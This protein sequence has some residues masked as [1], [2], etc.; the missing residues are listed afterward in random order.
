MMNPE[1]QSVVSRFSRT[2]VKD[3]TPI[4]HMT[5]VM[6]EIA[7]ILVLAIK[8]NLNCFKPSYQEKK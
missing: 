2:P 3:S 5:S 6:I 4:Q 8:P 1:E 7:F